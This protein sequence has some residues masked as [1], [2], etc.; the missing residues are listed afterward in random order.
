MR[1]KVEGEAPI[2]RDTEQG[3][4][5]LIYGEDGL[6]AI[7]GKRNGAGKFLGRRM[8]MSIICPSGLENNYVNENMR[9]KMR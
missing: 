6:E 9:G 4:M 8:I 1:H 5:A 3:L 2:Q 7:S